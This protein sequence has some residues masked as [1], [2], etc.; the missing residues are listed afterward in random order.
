MSKNKKTKTSFKKGNKIAAGNKS[1]AGQIAS[2]REERL[3]RKVDAGLVQRYI[4]VNSHLTVDEMKERL[5]DHNRGQI[6]F[7]EYMIIRTMVV[8][9]QTG[10]PARLNTII[11]RIAGK[12]PQKVT[13]GVDDPFEGKS[14]EELI[15]IKRKLEATNRQSLKYAEQTPRVIEQSKEVE[16]EFREIEASGELQQVSLNPTDKD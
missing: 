4:T 9:A 13:H 14:N 12:V 1:K 3:T 11:D 2:D 7:L 10:D 16:A 6:S 8:C 15:D 5:H